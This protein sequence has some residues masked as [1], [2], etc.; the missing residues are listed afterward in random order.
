LLTIA[1]TAHIA[2]V[3]GLEHTHSRIQM[4]APYPPLEAYRRDAARIG[5]GR[6]LGP[7]AGRWITMA[8]LLDRFANAVSEE[9]EQVARELA[10][11]LARDGDVSSFWNAA[12]ALGIE[13]EEAGASH[14]CYSWLCLL[15][16]IVPAER[17]LDLGRVR[18]FRARVARKLGAPDV[19]QA[20]YTEVERFGEAAAEPELTA[21]AWIGFGVLAVERGNNPEA[22]R[23]YQAAALV[24][25][26][27]GCDEQSSN[28]HQGLLVVYAMAG[29][30]ASAIAEGWRAF[31]SAGGDPF[32]ESE[33]LGNVAQAFH[34]MGH[35]AA[36]L[37]AFAA[38]VAR[39]ARIRV[40]LPALGGAALAAAALGNAPVVHA[41]AKRVEALIGNV[42]PYPV[43]QTLLDLADAHDWIGELA[44]GADYRA[45]AVAIA[46]A[47]ALH[48]LVFRAQERRSAPSHSKAPI[49]LGTPVSQVV[50]NIQALEAP[51][52]LFVAV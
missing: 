41:A 29:D 32:R 21:R 35:H 25:D 36:A 4:L 20:L 15:E 23:W 47:N 38:V 18:A 49:E 27:T 7:D 12:L 2:L 3:E 6:S 34:D 30:F 40:L 1:P 16:R 50:E 10:R 19:A 9:R 28:A 44:Q 51:P 33:I 39:G 43:A 37:R 17:V 24:A 14:L 48:Q 11:E 13:I 5:E 45:R 31:D 26:D 52:D 46:E 8:I 22:K 42:W